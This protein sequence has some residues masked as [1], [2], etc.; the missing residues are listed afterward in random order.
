MHATERG[1]RQVLPNE[2]IDVSY[3]SHNGQC[4][5]EDA[6][7]KGTGSIGGC[8][9]TW[10]RKKKHNDEWKKKN[11]IKSSF[12]LYNAILPGQLPHSLVFT[13]ARLRVRTKEVCNLCPDGAIW[14]SAFFLPDDTH[15]RTQQTDAEQH[16]DESNTHSGVAAGTSITACSNCMALSSSGW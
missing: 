11:Y 4:T 6:S 10:T 12:L 14:R 13:H 8:V 2:K 7:M 15:C 16:C 5:T 9:G 3:H 1:S